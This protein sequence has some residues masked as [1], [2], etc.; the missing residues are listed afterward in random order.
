MSGNF[1]LQTSFFPLIIDKW[2][3]ETAVKLERKG[4]IFSQGLSIKR[5]LIFGLQHSM[6]YLV[7]ASLLLGKK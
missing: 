7:L 6:F 4:V 1:S 5:D 2:C 3:F